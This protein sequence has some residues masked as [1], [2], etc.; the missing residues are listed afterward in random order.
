MTMPDNTL[1]VARRRMLPAALAW[2]AV[3]IAE[4]LFYTLLAMAIVRH[5]PPS[6][7]MLFGGLAVLATTI[8]ARAGFF[9]GARLTGDLYASLGQ[10]LTRAK[11]AW[12][13]DENRAKL[14]AVATRTIP[15]FMSIPAH[16][17][18]TFIHAPLLPLLLLPGTLLVGGWRAVLV[19][20][21]LLVLS[22]MA[23]FTAQRALRNADQRRGE[24]EGEANRV[25][26]DLVDHLELLR[27]AAG[28]I[29]AIRPAQ[30]IWQE[31]AAAM[32]R[33]NR[34]ASLASFVSAMA[35]AFPVVGMAIYLAL[36]AGLSPAAILALLLLVM[37]AAAPLE[38][39]A[40]AGIMLNDQLRA[41]R[42]F[43][44][45]ISAPSLPEPPP[46]LAENPVGTTLVLDKVASAP[47]LK[48]VSATIAP[49]DR[50]IVT[51]PTGSGKSTLL[52]LMMRFDDPEDG[53]LMLGGAALSRITYGKLAQHFAY[54]PQEPVVFTGTLA[55]NIRLGR[56][57]AS[58]REIE[59]IARRATLGPVIERSAMGIHQPVGHHGSALSGGER[60]R[61]AFARALISDA[62][63]LML[64]EA[65][66]ALDE[67][68]ER[69]LASLVRELQRTAIIV[70]HRNPEIWSP[71][72]QMNL[73]L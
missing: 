43:A 39:L 3:A 17:L 28:P 38:T 20:G 50:I 37:R 71:T 73:A 65:T 69:A 19:A 2:I 31:Q 55:D 18:Q 4:A 70:A 34:A 16:H 10:A 23:Q 52:G 11:L 22:F 64:D 63:I 15:G 45:V 6:L 66:S 60:Q 41:A 54:V 29:E 68:R 9:T 61:L 58:D 40:V 25:A 27:T 1:R 12:F 13:T 67:A 72:G 8:A 57:E 53:T 35:G 51:G 49:G 36:V 24:L 26:L 21:A 42:D 33:T 59:D 56:P 32:R 48:G 14:S 30:S 5:E 7:V 47:A 62:P 46:Q 44:T